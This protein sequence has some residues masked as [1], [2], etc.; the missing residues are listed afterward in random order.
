MNWHGFEVANSSG[1]LDKILKEDSSDF[2]IIRGPSEK[3]F[4]F[5]SI[6]LHFFIESIQP[7]AQYLFSS[8][9][10]LKIIQYSIS[11]AGKIYY[12]GGDLHKTVEAFERCSLNKIDFID[13]ELN[14][15][16][17]ADFQNLN[18]LVAQMEVKRLYFHKNSGNYK[19]LTNMLQVD[20]DLTI[21]DNPWSKLK[22]LTFEIDLF[23]SEF[24]QYVCD[25]RIF[26][27]L[28]KLEKL[29]LM[30][31]LNYFKNKN[32]FQDAS[33]LT[34]LTMT[35][36][37]IVH[38][39]DGSFNGLVNLRVLLVTVQRIDFKAFTCLEKLEELTLNTVLE[40]ISS[41]TFADLKKL[42]VLNLACCSI[43]SIDPTAFD[44]MKDLE[45]LNLNQNE[46]EEIKFTN[47][48]PGKIQIKANTSLCSVEFNSSYVSKISEI[49]LC[50]FYDHRNRIVDSTTERKETML[51]TS[52]PM[53][54]LTKLKIKPIG[55]MSFHQFLSL[56]ELSLLLT[57]FEDLRPGQLSCLSN[58]KTLT[59]SIT[60]SGK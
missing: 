34:H 16:Y 3:L 28:P 21:N 1:L 41:T 15:P 46:L 42:K 60:N 2:G 30:I 47:A 38:I 23:H 57:N 52:F 6:L 22:E 27:K 5:D 37:D 55:T 45:E 39:S 24:I 36:Y 19:K 33:N 17:N 59:L 29:K 12:S 51:V 56:N 43:K 20:K 53:N 50:G 14:D 18:Q 26:K 49:R 11:V 10:R 8:V 54:N 40:T 4:C 32:P 25:P 31:D 13:L 7:D 9:S 58:L 35:D 48:A 44:H